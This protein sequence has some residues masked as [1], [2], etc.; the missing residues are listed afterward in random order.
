MKKHSAS[1]TSLCVGRGVVSDEKLESMG[2]IFLPHL[3]IQMI[4]GEC[5]LGGQDEMA[6]VIQG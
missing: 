1:S 6:I 4:R 3:V 5:F 2:R